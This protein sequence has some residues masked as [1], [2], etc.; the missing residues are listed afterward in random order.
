MNQD[1]LTR[2]W[3]YSSDADFQA[4]DTLFGKGHHVWALATARAAIEK[5]LRACCA[6]MGVDG[7]LNPKELLELARMAQVDLAEE[8][9]SLL[10][11]MEAFRVDP[12]DPVA[13][14]LLY[15]KANRRFAEGYINRAVEL[16]QRLI[17]LL[18]G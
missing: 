4:M 15:R 2:H 9:K 16:R 7:F 6:T 8:Q 3:L 17:K 13:E 5:L 14:S 11:D 18:K 1:E 10:A 12:M